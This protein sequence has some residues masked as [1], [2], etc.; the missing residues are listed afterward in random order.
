LGAAFPVQSTTASGSV[1]R[2]YF[3]T[4][5]VFAVHKLDGMNEQIVVYIRFRN[6]AVM[7]HEVTGVQLMPFGVYCTNAYMWCG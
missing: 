2:A 4:M 6:H 7:L 3:N 1:D 5:L